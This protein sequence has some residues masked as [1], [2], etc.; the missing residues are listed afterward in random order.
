MAAQGVQQGFHA[1]VSAGDFKFIIDA[2][3]ATV[4]DIL[5]AGSVV[6]VSLSAMYGI[7]KYV[8]SREPEF[9]AAVNAGLGGDRA[10]QQIGGIE[11]GSICVLLR[12]FTDDRFLEVLEDYKSGKIKKRLR[13]EF[14]HIG[15]ETEGLVVDIENIENVEEK[16][17]ALKMR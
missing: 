3:R 17:E 7:Y 6:T 9:S 1:L 10:D 15:I 4:K 16:A 11:S 12:C 13:N 5:V 2:D 14:L 8:T